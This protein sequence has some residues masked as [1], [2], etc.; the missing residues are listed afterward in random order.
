MSH[1]L[2]DQLS[3]RRRVATIVTLGLLTGLGPF[4]VDL[5]LP[6]F[7][8]LKADL[9]ITD[10]QVQVTLSATTVGFALGQ[11][12][13]GPLSDRFGRRHPLL[14]AATLHVFASVMVAI[15]PNV[16]FLTT[17]RALQGIGA[18]GGAVVAMAMARD[19]FSGHRLV[20]MLSRLALINGLAPIIAPLIGS[21]MVTLMDWRGVFWALATYGAVL[22]ALV[23]LL[24]TETRPPEERTRGG[25]KQLRAAYA[26][27]LGDRLFV[28]VW[29]TASFAFAGLFSYISTSSLLLQ[30]TF[31]LSETQF[32]MVFAVC[33]VGV[34]AGVQ[35][36]SRLTRRFGPQWIL[37]AGTA[38][39]ILA[40]SALLGLDA[41]RGG[42]LPLVPAMFSFTLTFGC[43]MPAAQVLALQNHRENSGVA[44]SLMG[45]L[46]MTMAAIVGPVIGQFALTS[47]APMAWSMLVCA[48]LATISLWVIA[49]PRQIKFTL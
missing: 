31:G 36:G 35:L 6:T 39:M 2:G 8:A 20:V 3:A 25:L 47:A 33:S 9:D 19:L 29:L 49:R 40:A 48:V 41:L 13:I 4:T 1:H 12:I 18:A 46:N 15:S 21:W 38:G 23:W 45:A 34:F 22:V 16:H 30:E 37:V 32:G 28:G 42:Y 27:V 11:L 17:M 44:A 7:P 5:Y 43:C 26:H 14:I 10:P 24:I